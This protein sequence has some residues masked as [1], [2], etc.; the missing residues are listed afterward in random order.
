MMSLILVDGVHYSKFV[1]FNKKK[2]VIF[3]SGRMGGFY[4]LGKG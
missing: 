3:L 4:F 2:W 1:F